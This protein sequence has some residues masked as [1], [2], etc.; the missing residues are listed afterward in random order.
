MREG[1]HSASPFKPIL[2]VPGGEDEELNCYEY[3]VMKAWRCD[4]NAC[5]KWGRL[6]R[7]IIAHI[8]PH[9]FSAA[10]EWLVVPTSPMTLRTRSTKSRQFFPRSL[11]KVM[12]SVSVALILGHIYAGSRNPPKNVDLYTHSVAKIFTLCSSFW[13]A[14]TFPAANNCKRSSWLSSSSSL[15]LATTYQ[16]SM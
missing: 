2:A 11:S 6:I 1:L 7:W 4:A 16:M 10:A 12:L 9:A 13:H 14:L 3:A 15:S 8:V 5:S